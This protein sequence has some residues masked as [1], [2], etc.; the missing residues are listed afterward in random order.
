MGRSAS[1][2]Y[3]Q[4]QEEAVMSD[5]VTQTAFMSSGERTAALLDAEDLAGEA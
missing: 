4:I 1:H 5:T 3:T 2:P